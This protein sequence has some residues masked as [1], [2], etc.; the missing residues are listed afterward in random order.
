MKPTRILFTLAVMLLVLS[1]VGCGSQSTP[2]TAEPT[3]TM[4]AYPA[5]MYDPDE[6]A[7]SLT[8]MPDDVAVADAVASE[9]TEA[10]QTEQS[11]V[12]AAEPDVDNCLEC[13]TDQQTLMDTADP[14]AE[15]VSE[16]EGEG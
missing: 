3:A 4:H 10:P 6:V 15:V 7:A 5:P 14:V 8:A 16:N 9:P 12:I 13:H 2:T 11:E 1:V